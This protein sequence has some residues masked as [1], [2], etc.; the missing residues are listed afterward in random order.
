MNN[1]KQDRARP[2]KVVFYG[3][4][5]TEHEAQISALDNQMEW[6]QEL[7]SS[8]PNWTVVDQYVDEGIT[9]TQAKK[10]P[11][12]LRMIEDAKSG[13]FDLIVTREV[14]RFARNTVDTLSYTR[15]LAKLGVEVYFAADGIWTMD[16]DGEL[17]LSLMATLAQEESRKI[18]ERVLAGQRMSR[19][20][21]VLYGNGNILGYDLDK[22]NN[23]YVINE[24]QAET[25]RMIFEQYATGDGLTK[26]AKTLMEKGRKD[27]A[28][29]VNWDASK[30][31]RVL[32]KATYMGYCVYNRSRTVDYLEHRRVNNTD[33]D[34]YVMVKGDFP[35]IIDEELWY[36][37]NAIRKGR[38]RHLLDENGKPRRYGGT[39]AKNVWVTKL[40]CSCGAKFRRCLWQTKADGTQT[41]GFEC[42]RHTKRSLQF[43]QQHGLPEGLCDLKDFPEW[44]LELMAV[45]IF[46]AVWGSRREAV[47][48]ACR[49]LSACYQ[50][51]TADPAKLNALDKRIDGLNEKLNNLILM[52]ASNQITLKQFLEQSNEISA[53]QSRATREREE[54]LARESQ[55]GGL[56]IDAIE[57]SLCEAVTFTDGKVSEWFIQTFVKKVVP[58]D[59]TRFAWVLDL[60]PQPQTVFCEAT[61]RKEYPR[62]SL[63]SNLFPG[64]WPDIQDEPPDRPFLL[65]REGNPNGD[66]SAAE[67]EQGRQP[68]R[69]PGSNPIGL[70]QLTLH[71]EDAHA[72][73]K[74]RNCVVKPSRWHDIDLEVYL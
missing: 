30:V 33:E 74:A 24:E 65:D 19:E 72:F 61:G 2:R 15:E 8:H 39:I 22:A 17:R 43:L 45:K 59:G 27:G 6:Y 25:V 55:D 63:E 40:V 9:G 18:S 29:H 57:A 7:A 73:R 32:R 44:K 23:T 60:A 68:S 1:I 20:K 10:R 69:T 54:L 4:V 34:T 64:A 67:L 41:W 58:M 11:S 35:A 53:Q 5:S 3:R 36:K 71:F 13:K 66:I 37:C 50:R 51:E 48:E 14:C 42:Y 46:E 56:D 70:M 21:K 12:F 28:G 47:L 49:M 38:T 26:V 31:T 52:K 62:I 16:N